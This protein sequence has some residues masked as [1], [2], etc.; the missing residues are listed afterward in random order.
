MPETSQK[1]AFTHADITSLA[2]RLLD[3]NPNPAP[4]FLL[5][6]DLLHCFP[7]D[8]AFREAEQ[9]L[10]ESRWIIAL[11]GA[12]QPDGTWGRFHSQDSRLKSPIPTTEFAIRRS[13]AL[14]LDYRSPVIQ[15]ASDFIQAHIQGK[16]TW[17]DPPE[18][19]DDP[20]VFPYN[21]RSISAAMLALIEPYHPLLDP[22]WAKWAELVEAAFASGTYNAK[23][24]LARH[25]EL[26]GIPSKRLAHFPVYYPLIILSATRNRLPQD[27]EGRLLAF[28]LHKP[29]GIYY[30][31]TQS[32]D[33][34]PHLEEKEFQSWL[35]GQEILARFSG[36]KAFA[37]EILN[38]LWSQRNEA[39]Y[40]DM[41]KGVLH[42]Y[43]FPLSESWRRTENRMIDCTIKILCLMQR[44][45]EERTI[46]DYGKHP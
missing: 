44:Y 27:L 43:A 11:S 2:Q 42:S 41:G 39:G 5:M 6:R 37:P 15:K 19:H 8:A 9:H 20:R 30:I 12:Q 23:A 17:S 7:G 14:G 36:W 32:L 40:W 33:I 18:K 21:I 35:H 10:S 46:P 26:S 28:L 16:T 4:R 22:F 1:L 29:D 24:E 31:C 13:L 45:F 34:F 3:L 38:W 25:Q